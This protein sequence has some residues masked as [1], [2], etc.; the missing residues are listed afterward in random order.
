MHTQFDPLGK[1]PHA[2]LGMHASQLGRMQELWANIEVRHL[3][4]IPHPM[5][6]ELLRP[7]SL[8]CTSCKAFSHTLLCKAEAC[9][10]GTHRTGRADPA[11]QGF[12]KAFF[13]ARNQFIASGGR[14]NRPQ[15]GDCP[16]TSLR[17]IL[18]GRTTASDIRPNRG[19][20]SDAAWTERKQ[21]RK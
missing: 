4:K 17:T 8:L 12:R 5:E 11:M 19:Q 21:R 2:S 18:R 1:T 9:E 7:V 20:C 13:S 14:P 3:P 16:C 15:K 6:F 10:V